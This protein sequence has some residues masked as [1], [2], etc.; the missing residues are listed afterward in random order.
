M[1]LNKEQVERIDEALLQRAIYNSHNNFGALSWTQ[2]NNI[3]NKEIES[4]EE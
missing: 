2:M 3:I 4:V 1:V